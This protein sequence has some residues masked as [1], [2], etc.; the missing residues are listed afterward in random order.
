MTTFDRREEAFENRYAHDEELAFRAHA[1]RN[2][3]LGLWAAGHLGKHGQE[4]E[5]YAQ[6]MVT[7]EIE[8]GGDEAIV[9]KLRHD[10]GI[11]QVAQSEHQIRRKMDELLAQAL[12]DVRAA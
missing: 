5:E 4:A 8:G 2:H 10:F 11:V 6:A 7:A 12:V 9:T 3:K 1:R